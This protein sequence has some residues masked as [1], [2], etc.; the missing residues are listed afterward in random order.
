VNISPLSVRLATVL[1]VLLALVSPGAGAQSATQDALRPVAEAPR[2]TPAA[3]SA[4]SRQ[5]A[6]VTVFN[7]TV[8]TFRSPLLGIP[9]ED[10]A[11]RTRRSLDALLARG[12]KG[13]VTVRQEQLG[14]LLLI[15]GTLALILTE[16]DTDPV[17]GETLDEI[18]AATVARLSR[19]IAETRESRD[20]DALLHS[21]GQAAFAAAI[22]LASIWALRRLRRLA[23]GRLLHLIHGHAARLK[24]AGAELVRR[25][26]LRSGARFG[27]TSVY[28]LM[29]GIATYQWL[30]WTLR[31]FPFTR[32]WG[33]QLQDYLLGT[34][35]DIGHGILDAIPNLA[36]ALFILLLARGAVAVLRPAFEQIERGQMTSGW[37]DQDT[38]GPTRRIASALIWAFALVMA[39]PY[40]PGAHTEAFKGMSVLIGLMISLGASSVVAQ[41][42]SGIIL[43]YS[44][45]IRR[46]EYVR[47]GEQEG[48]VTELGLFT[49]RLR[50]GLGEEINMPNSLILGTATK[51]YSR[52]I[53]GV[54]YVVDTTVSIG[55]D[56]PWRQ[57]EAMLMEAAQRTDGILADPPPRVFQT[58]LADYYPVY[59]LVCQALPSVPRARAEVLTNLHANIQDVFNSHGVQI[60][61]PHYMNDTP[62]AKTVPRD[63]WYTA[64]AKPPGVPRTPDELPFR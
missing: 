43:M 61:S 2:T 28:W 35:A 3:S 20:M 59:R 48:T 54:G 4:A 13:E 37:L 16:G 42:A 41:A 47:I 30:S 9:A 52:A 49:T 18:T 14:R 53:K 6:N 44:R 21:A 10:R 5:E 40:L 25:D 56:T 63:R 31:A 19:V 7:R 46:G 50:N 62:E 22:Y 17:K 55:Y 24:L 11:R 45:V 36:T 23:A 1:A 26:R 32:W 64:P 58:E 8:A 15:D 29:I 38:V 34:L 12:G 39:Y 27:V 33:E 60:M 51:N 57:V